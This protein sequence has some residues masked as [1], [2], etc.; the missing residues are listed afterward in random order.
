VRITS[1]GG[2]GL[3]PFAL[4]INQPQVQGWIAGGAVGNPVFDLAAPAFL[5]PACGNASGAWGL[6]DT[7]GKGA[8]TVGKVMAEGYS[9]PVQVS[10]SAT[11]CN[12]ADSPKSCFDEAQGV[13]F[14]SKHLE[15][16]LEYLSGRSKGC[17][18]VPND[19]PAL[20]P[21]FSLPGYT[22]VDGK[23]FPIVGFAQVQLL[24]FEVQ[25]ANL[26]RRDDRRCPR[27]AVCPVLRN[28]RHD[29][30][31]SWRG[32]RNPLALARRT[33][34]GGER[35]RA[36]YEPSVSD[37][38]SRR[39]PGVRRPL[40]A[41]DDDESGAVS[42]RALAQPDWKHLCLHMAEPDDLRSRWCDLHRQGCRR[43]RRSAVHCLVDDGRSPAAP[44]AAAVHCDRTGDEG[45]R[46]R[47]RRPARSRQLRRTD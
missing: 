45:S 32:L 14:N 19:A 22:Q 36:E 23:S 34:R 42:K 10:S 7:D 2:G 30:A 27:S 5:A 4:C 35:E 18:G 44:A 46:Y 1:R 9:Q 13:K 41:G 29:P 16:A 21:A 3:R 6:M 17:A 26:R 12:K 37:C 15:S 20:G 39:L 33:E 38:G 8:V 31:C 28:E 11:A 25:G 40:R 24:C 43:G 47:S